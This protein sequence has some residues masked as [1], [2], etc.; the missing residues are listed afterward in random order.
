MI[1]ARRA[2]LLIKSEIVNPAEIAN[3]LGVVPDEA[4]WKG[5]PRPGA[6][7]P[8]PWDSN[9][10]V[11][12][13]L[14]RDA[15]VSIA[16]LLD[17]LLVR[18]LLIESSIR[19]LAELGCIIQLSIVQIVPDGSASRGS[20]ALDPSWMKALAVFRGSLSVDLY[21]SHGIAS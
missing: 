16:E 1:T 6:R 9:E 11:L 14:S 3:I 5:K 18:V 19:R 15:N 8:R 2:E 20:F 7:V 4:I 13:E 21:S 12:R 17:A 10:V